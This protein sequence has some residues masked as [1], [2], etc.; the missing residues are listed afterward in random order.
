M[1]SDCDCHR[2]LFY[3]THE[4]IPETVAV[5][6]WQEMAEAFR[7]SMSRVTLMKNGNDIL[8][9]NHPFPDTYARQDEV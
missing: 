3:E 2:C 7:F 4:D 8:R 5:Q 6:R 9:V 1:D